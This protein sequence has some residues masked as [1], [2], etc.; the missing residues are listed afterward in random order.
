MKPPELKFLWEYVEFWAKQDPNFISV[1]YKR[2]TLT[3]E[4]INEQ[5]NKLAMAFLELGVAKGDTI[6]TVLPT[7]PEFLLCFIAASKIGA[8]TVPMDK[9]YKMTDFKT[10]I[11]H[12]NPKVIITIKKWQKNKIADNLM[13]L[14]KEFNKIKF[15]MIGKHELGPS[16]DQILEKEYN[17]QEDLKQ[18]KND[19]DP[20]DCT[21]VIWTGGTTGAPK[22]VEISHTN[23]IKMC[24]I[25]YDVIIGGLGKLGVDIDRNEFKHLVNLPVSHV[26]GTIEIMGTGMIGGLE[27]LFQASWSPWDALKAMKKYRLP[28][29]GGVPTM[30]KI[31]L[32][33]PDLDNYAPKENLRLIV[34]SGEKVSYDIINSIQNRI[35][36]NIIIGYGSTEAG[37]EVTFTEILNTDE[38]FKRVANGY[39]GKALPGMDI[40]IVDEDFNELP[41]GQTGEIITKGPLAAKSYFKM[42]QED[43]AGFTPDGYCRTGDLGFLEE[44]GSLFITGRIKEIIRVGAYTVYPVE[45]EELVLTHPKVAIAAALG[46]PDEIKGEIVWLVIGPELGT[47]F[48]ESDK[49][50]ILEKC[51]KNLAKFKVPEK[52]IVYPLDPNDLPI[53]R[54]GK[55]DKVRLKKELIPKKN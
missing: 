5:S 1:R 24:L 8:I 6:C 38:Q 36:N 29:M 46:A 10:L 32:S 18:A 3:S 37:S 15:I 12:T 7:I 55:V 4:E 26:G 42:P 35:C 2:K 39:V 34:L 22:A 54:I 16:L 51:K 21:L 14:S 52:L 40:K 41:I 20:G 28:F 49:Q 30:F 50:E 47:K 19:Q 13:E 25:E 17:L 27:M 23:I 9:E 48:D 31:F 53:T 33:L 45:I 43:K 44:D 11:P